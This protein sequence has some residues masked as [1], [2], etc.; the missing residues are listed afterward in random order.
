MLPQV[1]SSST[2]LTLSGTSLI[3]NDSN[4]TCVQP[5]GSG[6]GS[7][8]SARGVAE[9]KR[10]EGN[11]E[12]RYKYFMSPYKKFAK[13]KGVPTPA[14]FPLPSS[15]SCTM[16]DPSPRRPSLKRMKTRRIGIEQ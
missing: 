9:M 5:M 14:K 13:F 3:S 12:K 4:T 10:S 7:S 11:V 8:P 6:S 16:E 1:H 2:L 15:S